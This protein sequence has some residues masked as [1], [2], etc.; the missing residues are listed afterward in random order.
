MAFQWKGADM[1]LT[2]AAT[3]AATMAGAVDRPAMYVVSFIISD[4]RNVHI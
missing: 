1:L 3:D 2:G 4:P